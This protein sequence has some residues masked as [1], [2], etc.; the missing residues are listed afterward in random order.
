MAEA[1]ATRA[2]TIDV[3]RDRGL[4]IVFGDGHECF[5][6]N[7][8]L[9]RECPCATCRDYR[10]RGEDAWPRPDSPP[11]ARIENAELVGGW[12]ISFAWND[13]HATGIF[14]FEG[15]RSWCERMATEIA[16]SS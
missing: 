8:D 5:F 15:L 6:A 10:D 1:E 3:E 7:N 13:G 11:E 14:P 2:D 9:R 16:G 4:T 12:G